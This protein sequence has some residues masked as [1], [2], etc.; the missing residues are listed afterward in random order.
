MRHDKNS[1]NILY[2][3]V[4]LCLETMRFARNIPN[5]IFVHSFT[6]TF[7]LPSL[8]VMEELIVIYL[9]NTTYYY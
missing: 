3:R 5:T 4:M 6:H 1:I 7:I 2:C 9:C 8:S